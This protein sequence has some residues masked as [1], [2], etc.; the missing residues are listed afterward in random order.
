MKKI[1][2]IALLGFVTACGHL[3]NPA[4][5]KVDLKSTRDEA[6]SCDEINAEIVDLQRKRVST[7][8]QITAQVAQ[9]IL[10]GVGGWF[11]IVP[12][13]FI[14]VTTDKNAAYN[15]Y[16]DREGYIRALAAQKNCANVP[17]EFQS[18]TAEQ[19]DA[20]LARSN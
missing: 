5:P 11:V 17:P 18:L 15:S 13:F 1:A 8:K 4:P 14:D 19:K 12:F 7:Q 3:A 2:L 9:N 10:C 6:C 20:L 16:A